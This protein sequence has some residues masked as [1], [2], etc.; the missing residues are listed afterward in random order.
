[1]TA[2]EKV[3]DVVSKM[4]DESTLDDIG[5]R[6]YAIEGVEESRL[7]DTDIP[8]TEAQREVLDER[9]AAVLDDPEDMLTWPELKA[10]L[11]RRS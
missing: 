2:K 4:P 3:L 9:L 8:L 10:R 1:M 11:E 7:D 5:Y 6:I